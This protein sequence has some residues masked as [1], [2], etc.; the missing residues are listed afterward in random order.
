MSKGVHFLSQR[1]KKQEYRA[2]IRICSFCLSYFVVASSGASPTITFD[3]R[4]T[5]I[6]IAYTALFSSLTTCCG[7]VSGFLARIGKF[8]PTINS[9]MSLDPNVLVIANRMDVAPSNGNVTGSLWCIPV[10][11]KNNY[12]S[13]PLNTTASCLSLRS[14][15]PTVDAPTVRE[16]KRAGAAIIIGRTNLHELAL[17]GLSA[18]SLG[19]QTVNPYARSRTPGGSSGATG[20]AITASLA[21]IGPGT[22]C[23]PPPQDQRHTPFR[24][25]KFWPA[26]EILSPL[27]VHPVAS[28]K[29]HRLKPVLPRQ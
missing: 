8:N 5:T 13:I 17:E 26:S 19:G 18:S 25:I 7:V 4:E 12:D 10:L 23:N 3:G 22:D 20:A 2:C 16:L 24:K 1:R 21:V 14:S 9:I 15:I 28:L 6:E 29:L 11:L 27:Q